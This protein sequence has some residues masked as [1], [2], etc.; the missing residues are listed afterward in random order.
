MKTK[1]TG[2]KR[3]QGWRDLLQKEQKEN[4]E[5]GEESRSSVSG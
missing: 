1:S 2:G 3:P 4:E 5:K